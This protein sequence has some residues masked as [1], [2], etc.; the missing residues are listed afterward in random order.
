MSDTENLNDPMELT[1]EE[2]AY[3]DNGGVEPSAPANEPAEPEETV[4][5]ADT[6]H[7]EPE[8][9]IDDTDDEPEQGKKPGFVPHR[10]LHKALEKVKAKEAEAAKER[11]ERIRLEERFNQLVQRVQQPQQ[12]Q[13]QVQEPAPQVAP[14]PNEDIFGA[15]QHQAKT[16]EQVQAE[17]TAYKQQRAQEEQKQRIIQAAGAAEQQFM[18]EAPDYPDAL[19]HLRAARVAELQMFGLTEAQ[20]RAKVGQEE[21]Q[22]AA[23]ALQR[24]QN[25]AKLAYDWAKQ[26]GYAKKAPEPAPEPPAEKLTRQAEAQARSGTLSHGGGAPAPVKLDARTVA[27]MSE[28][29][30]SALME[31]HPKA[32]EKLLRGD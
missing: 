31:K 23:Q 17:I 20:A 6:G 10:K 4:L 32:L 12:Q 29:E 3:F 24:G 9:G 26:R 11:E 5:E 30:F 8:D 2:Q 19:N 28:A 7:D 25:P 18:A 27:A 16:I 13:P 15:V 1:P 14:D 22:L 21:I